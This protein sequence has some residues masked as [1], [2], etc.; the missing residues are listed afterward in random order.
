MCTTQHIAFDLQTVGLLNVAGP[1]GAKAGLAVGTLTSL[2]LIAL[3]AKRA[4]D[5]GELWRSA[6]RLYCAI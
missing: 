2:F 6:L 4:V 1:D 3:Y 5:T